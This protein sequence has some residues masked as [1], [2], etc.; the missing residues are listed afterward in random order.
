MIS[1]RLWIVVSSGALALAGMGA[2]GAVAA[3]LEVSYSVQS[4]QRDDQ[5]EA[6]KEMKAGNQL[7]LREIEKRVIPQMGKAEYLGPTYD[8]A[9]HAYRLKFIKNGRVVY[10]DV[11]AR[12]GRIINRSG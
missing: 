11:D 12:T 1:N 2:S 9:A 5:G 10:V 6:R 4:K 3:A 7:S 8:A